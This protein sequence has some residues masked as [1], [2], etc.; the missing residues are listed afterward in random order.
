MSQAAEFDF[1][2]E[3]QDQSPRKID[4]ALWKR[5]FSYVLRYKNAVVATIT[6]AVFTGLLEMAFP[7]LTKW[8]I[9]DAS[10]NGLETNLVWWSSLY[11]VLCVA[12]AIST[13]SFLWYTAK[14]RVFA[15]HDIRKAAFENLQQLS[16]AY[17][18]KRPVGWLVARLTSDTERLTNIL[19]WALLDLVWGLS[20]MLA[21]AVALA[22][23][24]W[25]IFLAAAAI[26]PLVFW[27]SAKIR[28]SILDSARSVRS[29]NSRITASFNE[30][31]MGVIASKL[32]VREGANLG[33][34][35]DLTSKMYRS[36]VRN[37]TIA[38]IYV[39]LV[40]ICSSLGYAIALAIGGGDLLLGSIE[41]GT[42]IALMMLVG[43][44]FDP[45]EFIGHWFAEIQM[46]Q[47]SAERVLSVIDER[48]TIRD[49]V[50][51]HLG[52]GTK[53]S[54]LETESKRISEIQTIEFRNVSFS[55]EPDVLVLD[56]FNLNV[57]RGDSIAI[58][59]PTGSGKTTLVNLLARM[60]EPTS[61]QILFNGLDYRELG[62]HWLR[63]QLGMVLQTPHV[64]SGT[65]LEN[66]RYG[67]LNATDQEVSRAISL[68]GA[69]EFIARLPSKWETEV[70]E[71]GSLLSIGQKQMISYAR[72]V[73]GDPQILILDEATSSVDT[74]TERMIQQGTEPL[75]QGRFSFVVAHR[76]STIESATQVVLIDQGKLV[77]QGT[78]EELLV[79][80]GTYA[81][82]KQH[83]H[84]LL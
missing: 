61:G 53:E 26:L 27:I 14:I 23:L 3:Y 19:A 68:V 56:N 76:L 72:A 25:K 37:L 78:H 13:T 51:V 50:S 69:E 83:D 2:D 62:L 49:S 54:A 79:L 12:L 57:R 47:A 5:L 73:L 21:V 70:G 81:R 8:V 11:I 7:L 28:R 63:R 15:A 43:H 52:L 22:I 66:I 77:E 48:P 18:D 31:I 60:F 58:V 6:A 9:D 16:I 42:L 80:N 38:A 33:E 39:P 17:F 36:S 30:H 32:F 59:G 41:A 82:L 4:L 24:N 40:I 34:F 29:T 65:I 84:T 67:H 45:F 1:F 44:F 64:F 35:Q 20:M 46:A 74:E 10:N 75:L 71:G 55:Y